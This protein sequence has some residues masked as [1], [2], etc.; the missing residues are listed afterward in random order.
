MLN[1]SQKNFVINISYVLHNEHDTSIF[2][3][4]LLTHRVSLLEQMQIS[5]EFF[6]AGSGQTIL[7]TDVYDSLLPT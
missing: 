2:Y 4:S 5:S 1:I 7:F 6:K 3:T